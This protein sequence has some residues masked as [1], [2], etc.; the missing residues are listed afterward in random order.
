M[1]RKLQITKKRIWLLVPILLLVAG[2]YLLITALAPVL[3]TPST[4]EHIYSDKKQQPVEIKENRLYIP[5]ISVDVAINEGTAVVLEKGAW[6]RRPENG[7]PE[8][9]GNFVLSAHRFEIGFTPQ[10]TRAK[11]PFYHIDKLQAGDKIFI[12]YNQKRYAYEVTKKYKV[13]RNAVQIEAP[14]AEPKMTLYSCDLRGEAAGREVIE[15]KPFT[16]VTTWAYKISA[17]R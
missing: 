9:G 4:P 10:Q 7:N 5:T 6:H 15:A 13:D 17:R 11:S 8:K 3:P 12:D 2:T 14:S 1:K 16:P